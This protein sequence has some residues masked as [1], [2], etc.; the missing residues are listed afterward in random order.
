V[1]ED[2]RQVPGYSDTEPIR[3][4]PGEAIVVECVYGTQP[5]AGVAFFQALWSEDQTDAGYTLGGKVTLSSADVAG[6]K[7]HVLTAA[8][9]DMA[10]AQ[11]QTL[12]TNGTGDYSTVLASAVKASVFVQHQDGPTFYTDE[13]KPFIEAP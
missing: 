4:R 13:G 2:F 10:G 9:A 7:V 6:A 1:S 12:T 11:L 8:T 5:T 3:L